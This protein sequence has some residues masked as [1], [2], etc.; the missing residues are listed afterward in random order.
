[1]ANWHLSLYSQVSPG[2]LHSPPLLLRYRSRC[3]QEIGS[4]R[5]GPKKSIKIF[6]C[7]LRIRRPVVREAP[8]TPKFVFVPNANP[9]DYQP[10]DQSAD[11]PSTS[12]PVAEPLLGGVS[13]RNAEEVSLFI[14][15]QQLRV[16][17]KLAHQS[18]ERARPE[19]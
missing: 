5:N 14:I 7:S 1:M 18:H 12:F 4:A 9:S 11:E 6:S 13:S 8:S 3:F 16:C 15:P 10:L 17:S 19:H 2:R